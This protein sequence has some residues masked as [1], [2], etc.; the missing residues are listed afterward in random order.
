MLCVSCGRPFSLLTPER[1]DKR[2]TLWNILQQNKEYEILKS[3][4]ETLSRLNK[5]QVKIIEELRTLTNS[6]RESLSM[7]EKHHNTH[8]SCGLIL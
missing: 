2:F 7:L 4:N 1:D 5:M 8:C 3:E 6:Q